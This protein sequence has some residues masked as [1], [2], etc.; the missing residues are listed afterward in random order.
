MAVKMNELKNS[1]T[2]EKVYRLYGLA[3]HNCSNIEYKI[4]HYLLGPEWEKA[5]VLSPEE[6]DKVSDDLYKKTLGQLLKKYKKHFELT[7]EAPDI[8]DEVLEK[9]NYLA[10]RFFGNYGKKMHNE[11]TLK[12][13]TEDLEGMIILF[14]SVSRELDPEYKTNT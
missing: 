14:Q 3:A 8:L 12:D 1:S 13:M 6:V 9:R 5:D 2:L 11:E 10:H 4:A 7:E